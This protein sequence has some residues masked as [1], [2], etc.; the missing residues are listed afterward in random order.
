MTTEVRQA[1][2]TQLAIEY[3]DTA[4]RYLLCHQNTQLAF[5]KARFAV[6]DLERRAA[7]TESKV[8]FNG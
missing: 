5:W 4:A 7:A 8:V 3:A 6:R 2:A 1:T